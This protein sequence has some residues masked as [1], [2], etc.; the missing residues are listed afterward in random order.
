MNLEIQQILTQALGFFILLFILKK[1]AWKPLLALLEERREKISLE[2]K[3]IE[4]VK[5]ELSRLEEDY[6]AKL[7]DID[8]QAR[9][10][11]QEAIA[12]AQ[13]IS[14]EIQEKSRDEAKKTLD[15]AKANIELEIAKARV[16]LRNQVASIAIKAAEKVLKEELNEEK[17]RRLVMGFIE[18]LEQVR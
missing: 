2:F 1:F 18:D 6:K 12:E 15:K 4:Q 10:K 14:I 5:S 7:A 8:T 17:H 3:N 9:L 11:I 16:D 13:R